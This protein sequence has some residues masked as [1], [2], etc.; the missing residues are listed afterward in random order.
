[1]LYA[2][3]LIDDLIELLQEIEHSVRH[4]LGVE[5]LEDVM[6]TTEHESQ[7]ATYVKRFLD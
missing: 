1:M 6:G 5:S 7:L 3:V 2:G 4:I